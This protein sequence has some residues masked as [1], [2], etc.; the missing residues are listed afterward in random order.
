MTSS[1][2]RAVTYKR[3][4][5]VDVL[6]MGRIPRATPGPL[7]VL[8]RPVAVSLN[9]VDVQ[10]R[11]GLER[12]Y[13]TPC[14]PAVP[15]I[16]VAGVVVELGADTPEFAIDDAVVGHAM[17]DFVGAGTLAEF[18]DMP[19]RSTIRMPE[20]LT[21][22][23]AATLPLAAQTALQVIRRSELQ[24][25]DRVLVSG[26]AGGVGS[27]AVQ[28]AKRTGA[29]VVGTASHRNLTYVEDLGAMAIDYRSDLQEATR[30]IAPHGF[31]V[32]FDLVGGSALDN[33]LTV[34]AKDGRV[35]SIADSR[36]RDKFGGQFVWLRPSTADL[37]TVAE[38]VA[39]RELRTDIGGV[40]RFDQFRSAFDAFEARETRGKTIIEFGVT[41]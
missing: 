37:R 10:I 23:E 39:S 6:S 30:A 2:M 26:A 40:Y 18:V 35:T 38:L 24:A 7:S 20:G 22:R 36:A 25:A 15:G 12:K 27:F 17:K 29:V 9:P 32:V 41:T 21:F 13:L 28:L 16:D 8:V 11:E 34:M 33:A 5:G 31:D 4:G 1:L 19:V 3:F 14:F